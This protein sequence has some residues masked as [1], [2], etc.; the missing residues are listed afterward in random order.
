MPYTWT[1]ADGQTFRDSHEHGVQQLTTAQ[2]L[3]ESSN[4]GT[5]QIGE[6]LSSDVR[7]SYIERFGFGSLTGIEMPAESAG[8][9]GPVSEWD[10]RTSYTTMF[11]QGI[12]GT[13]LQ[14]VQ[15]LATVA[16]KGLRVAPAS[17]T[18][19]SIPAGDGALRAGRRACASSPSPLPRRSPRCS[20]A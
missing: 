4:V 9:V 16:H 14:S 15:V 13:A 2:V 11:G 18:P 17:S 1:S 8:I 12:A 7:H 19:G 5:V 3:A 10:D 20:S 6:R